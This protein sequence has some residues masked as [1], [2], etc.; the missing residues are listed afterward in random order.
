MLS[1]WRYDLLKLTPSLLENEQTMTE[2]FQISRF[3]VYSTLAHSDG[4][5]GG[6]AHNNATIRTL[7]ACE[8]LS[9]DFLSSTSLRMPFMAR[10][11]LSFTPNST[12]FH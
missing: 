10:I 2:A 11:W 5:G 1:A 3:G 6:V 4:S 9:T 8:N 12:N 7:E